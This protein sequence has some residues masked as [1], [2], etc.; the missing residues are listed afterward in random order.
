MGIV[1]QKIS[2]IEYYYY[3]TGA[4]SK[5]QIFLGREGKPHMENIAKAYKLFSKVKKRVENE[6]E[7]FQRLMSTQ[8]TTQPPHS[9]PGDE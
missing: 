2:G 3:K 8:S 5:I 6:E 4:N 1:L 9:T 7:I